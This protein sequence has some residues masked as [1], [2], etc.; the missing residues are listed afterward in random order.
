MCGEIRIQEPDGA[1]RVVDTASLLEAVSVLHAF[2]KKTQ[3]TAQRDLNLIRF[4]LRLV[5]GER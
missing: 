5:S 2:A 1:F 4:R 3:A